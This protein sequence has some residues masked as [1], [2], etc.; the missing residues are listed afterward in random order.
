MWRSSLFLCL[1]SYPRATGARMGWLSR[2]SRLHSPEGRPSTHNC[3]TH[4]R[5]AALDNFDYSERRT[6]RQRYF[7]YDAYWAKGGPILFYCG[8]RLALPSDASARD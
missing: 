6:F 1:A 7:L 3:T 2:L 8:A 4:W 5:D